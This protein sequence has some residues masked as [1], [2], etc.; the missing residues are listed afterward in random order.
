MS[1][2]RNRALILVAAFLFSGSLAGCA[3]MS[4]SGAVTDPRETASS[5]GATQLPGVSPRVSESG[6][7]PTSIIV[8]NP[9]P[10]AAH[11]VFFAHFECSSGK[12]SV[13]LADDPSVFMGGE[14][15]GPADY[16][17]TLPAGQ[18]QYT[19]TIDVGANSTYKFSGHFS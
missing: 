10:G 6:T 2:R 8:P 3:T 4:P 15:S 7:G 14:C 18:Q 5:P 9:S 16:Q 17:M 1:F 11:V 19:F 13:T 12:G